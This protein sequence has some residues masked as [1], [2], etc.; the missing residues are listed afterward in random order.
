MKNATKKG[1]TEAQIGDGVDI[2]SRMQFHRGT[3]QKGLSQT[4]MTDGG[5]NVGV[6]VNGKEKPKN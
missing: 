4:L 1:Y 3:V 5:N 6:V 2:S